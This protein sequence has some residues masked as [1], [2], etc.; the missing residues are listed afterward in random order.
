MTT[1][2]CGAELAFAKDGTAYCD[3]CRIAVV[4]GPDGSRWW[5]RGECRGVDPDL[6]FPR[7]GESVT[8]AVAICGR[9]TVSDECLESA[10]HNREH[11]GIWGGTTGADRRRMRRRHE[12][13]YT[14]RQCA[15]RFTPDRPGVRYCT[16][17]C[18]TTAR[19]LSVA[20]S[21]RRRRRAM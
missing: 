5:E 4:L 11:F 13:K 7:P 9:C 8:E 14:C 19:A 3:P 17:E 12:V 16:D 2:D 6:F 15:T 18:R 21:N 10:I 20:E 1:H